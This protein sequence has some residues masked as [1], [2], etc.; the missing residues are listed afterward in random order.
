[1]FPGPP[2][3]LVSNSTVINKFQVEIRQSSDGSESFLAGLLYLISPYR[4]AEDIQQASIF[5]C[6]FQS[7]SSLEFGWLLGFKEP[8]LELKGFVTCRSLQ[9][10]RASAA[11]MSPSAGIIRTAL[12][13]FAL[14]YQRANICEYLRAACCDSVR[15][16]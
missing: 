16:H 9:N 3:Q 2:S 15:L 11:E 13:S 4:F 6:R 12:A 1:M 14:H 8:R 10:L 5:Y 7:V